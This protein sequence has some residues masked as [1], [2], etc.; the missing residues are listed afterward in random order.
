MDTIRTRFAPSPTGFLHV[1]GL[2][3]ALFNYLFAKKNRGIFVLRIEDT[4]QKRYVPGSVELIVRSLEW[5]HIPADEGIVLNREHIAERGEY[6]PYIQ[7]KRLPVYREYAEKLVSKNAAYEEK[8]EDQSTTIRFRMNRSGFTEWKDLIHKNIRIP[9]D[10]QEDFV[11][12]KSDGYPTYNFANVIDDHL[13]EISHVIRGEEFLSSV[14]KHVA[15]Y[16]A[17]EWDIPV[18]AHLPLLLNPDRSKLSKRVGDVSVEFYKKSGYL[19]EA[20]VNFIAF[21]GWNP[22]NDEEFFSLQ[23]LVHAFEFSQV[24]KAGAVFDVEKLGWYNAHYLKQLSSEQFSELCFPYLSDLGFTSDGKGYLTPLG[25][26]LNAERYRKML[27]MSRERMKKISD[28]RELLSFC[29]EFPAYDP[30]LLLWKTMDAALAMKNLQKYSNFLAS[31]NDF[32]SRELRIQT[33]AF[34]AKNSL[35]TGEVL[36]PFRIS[37]TGKKASP[38]P[39]DIAEVLGKAEVEKR[40][41]AAIGLLS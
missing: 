27:E 2:R 11:I 14:P 26:H 13:M 21:L 4:D 17:F 39:F 40:I 3:T 6:G 25:F 33:E 5:A 15:L 34:I 9:N 41:Q 10:Q 28:I 35:K 37:L 19:P 16:R 22:K 12:L 36:W 31:L 23:E 1:G 7:S 24:N 32:K 30:E 29:I 18:F 20:I 38:D 8:N